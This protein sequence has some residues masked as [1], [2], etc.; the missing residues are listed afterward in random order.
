M[1]IS[2][3]VSMRPVTG[4]PSINTLTQR[5]PVW[6]PVISEAVRIILE[7]EAFCDLDG[8]VNLPGASVVFFQQS[9]AR[10]SG[11]SQI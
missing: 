7:F 1:V 5:T 6:F 11:L 8:V 2:D 10:C 9:L 3:P 4:T